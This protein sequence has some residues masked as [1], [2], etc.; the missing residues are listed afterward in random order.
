[1]RVRVSLLTLNA[2]AAA[3]AAVPLAAQQRPTPGGGR[4]GRGGAPGAAGADTSGV[5]PVERVSTTKHTITIG[6]RQIAYTAN[7]GT[8]VLHDAD[9]KP[10]AT[11]FYIS[12]T[13][14]DAP[15]G[16]RP[17]TF[18]YNGGPGSASIWLDMGIMSPRAPEMGPNGTEPAPPYTIVDNQNSPLDVTDLVQVD[19]MM[20]GYSRPGPGVRA[21]DY[22]GD[23]NDI[24]MFAEFVRDYLDKYKR[25]DSPK[26]LFGESYGTF[27]SAGLASAL[28]DD[29][30]IELN[31][32]M[33]LGT[34]LDMQYI[35]QGPTNDIGWATYLPTYT[36]TAW[37]HKKL[38]TDLQSVPLAQVVQQARDYAFGDYLTTLARGNKLSAAERA[39]AAAK[40]ARF[41]GL[42]ADFLQ[43]SNL[44]VSAGVYR[45]ELLRDQR[46]TVGRYDSRMIGLNGNAASQ[47][48]DYDPSDEAPSGAFMSAFMRYLHDDLDYTTTLQYYRGGH[49]GAW[50]YSTGGR[51][52]YPSE[53]EPLRLAM[54]KNPY[55]KV[56]VGA[57]Y[58]D[59]ATPF[60]NAEYTFDH[61][62]Y[63]QTYK[64]RVSF[65]YYES[66]HMAYLNQASA[67]QLKADIAAF[68][69]STQHP[70]KA[71]QEHQ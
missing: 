69:T 40:L 28:Q 46:K 34:V 20:T 14:D 30:G 15:T 66:G 5:A 56:M 17:V 62:G 25:W 57:G 48:Q 11:V 63:D 27:R 43:K 19:A 26:Y 60:A 37:Y 1:M 10:R 16:T 39:A 3:G 67:K 4:G 47:F 53:S 22:T 68:I 61:L 7:T 71:V 29:E 6:G 64:D 9:G 36:A 8:M 21:S 2:A 24:S 50:A 38:P 45:T 58:Y 18:F 51:G 31:G 65:K 59:M 55:L 13:K 54:A 49:T 44:R 12:Y 23:R 32:I 42:S 33:L 70:T 41:T 35:T 52:G